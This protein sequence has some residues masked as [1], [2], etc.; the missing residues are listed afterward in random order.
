ME[1]LAF[2]AR[3]KRPVSKKY[4]PAAIRQRHHRVADQA[5]GASMLLIR[6]FYLLLFDVVSVE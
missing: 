2:L 5:A 4:L 6:N 1:I 3:A